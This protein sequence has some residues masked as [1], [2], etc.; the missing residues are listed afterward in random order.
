M[1]TTIEDRVI[2]L[3]REQVNEVPPAQAGTRPSDRAVSSTIAD[4]LPW[5]G[6][7][8]FWERLAD[9]TQIASRRWRK[10]YAREHRVTSDMFEALAKAFPQYAF[11]L[12]TGITDTTN[13]HVAPRTAQCF[14][15]R[16]Y[17]QSPLADR[18]FRSALTLNRRLYEEGRVDLE[19]EK[20][21]MYAAERTRP[22]VHWHDSPLAGAAYRIAASAEYEAFEVLWQERELERVA[23]TRAILG[24]DRP[25]AKKR[26]EPKG[27][28][29]GAAPMLGLDSRTLHQDP[30]D[31]FYQPTGEP[32]TLFALGVMNIP[33]AELTGDELEVLCEWLEHMQGEDWT[34]LAKYLAHHGLPREGIEAYPPGGVGY[35]G[36]GMSQDG[37]DRF[38]ARVKAL[39]RKGRR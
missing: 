18:Y 33:P 30:W 13:G 12:A 32:P 39:K 31:L 1:S 8:G 24:K 14:P 27:A 15:E 9:V 4:E 6:G 26:Q 25:A 11:W 23:R 21:R 35:A 5:L 7:H 2:L 16:L 34:V 20:A 22:L 10:I 36:R 29:P 17:V 37:I 38:A 3:L 28:G 19:D